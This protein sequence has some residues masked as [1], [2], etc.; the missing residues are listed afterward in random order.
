MLKNIYSTTLHTHC[1]MSVQIPCQKN[2][3]HIAALVF[4]MPVCPPMGVIW[5]SWNRVSASSFDLTA[6]RAGVLPKYSVPSL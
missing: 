5:H 4:P 6:L 2:L 1:S 3:L